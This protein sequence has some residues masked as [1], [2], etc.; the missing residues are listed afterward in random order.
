MSNIVPVQFKPEINESL[1][2]T[3]EVLLEK[4]KSG[5]LVSAQFVCTDANQ[6]LHTYFTSTNNALLELAAVARLLHRIQIRLDGAN[7]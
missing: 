3:L 2:E 1:V 6:E 7:E 4:A 5:E